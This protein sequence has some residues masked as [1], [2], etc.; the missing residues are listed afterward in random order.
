[1]YRL[2][3]IRIPGEWLILV[4]TLIFLSSML[5]IRAGVAAASGVQRNG[6]S[7]FSAFVVGIDTPYVLPAF[8]R[9]P[10][11][12]SKDHALMLLGGSSGRTL[13]YDCKSSLVYRVSDEQV[14]LVS[15]AYTTGFSD[16][17]EPLAASC[18]GDSWPN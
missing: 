10:V 18:K 9:T 17:L 2:P 12:Y 3:S 13:L 16:K 5:L 11:G 7:S 6:E 14:E 4:V 1:M 15:Y 8:S